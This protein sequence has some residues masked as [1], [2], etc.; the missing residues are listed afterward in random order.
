MT[1]FKYTTDD[2]SPLGATKLWRATTQLQRETFVDN[3][4]KTVDNIHKTYGHKWRFIQELCGQIK[5]LSHQD[6]EF[7]VNQ[8]GIIH[9]ELFFPHFWGYKEQSKV[10]I[11]A[12]NANDEIYCDH[13]ISTLFKQARLRLREPIQDHIIHP[14]I[15]SSR[16]RS[17][18][19]ESMCWVIAGLQSRP[20][21]EI[22]LKLPD[23]FTIDYFF[24]T[25]EEREEYER[26]HNTGRHAAYYRHTC[27]II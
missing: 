17:S 18:L 19:P 21:Y 3:I 13:G 27:G 6:P 26:L 5:N 22:S 16:P 25:Q 12:N 24:Q 7:A 14:M 11:V 20:R 1:D 9:I 23:E 4:R 10:N 8:Q 15:Q 2:Y